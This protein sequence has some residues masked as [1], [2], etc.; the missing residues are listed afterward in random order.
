MFEEMI[1]DRREKIFKNNDQDA[2]N[3]MGD[4]LQEY[5]AQRKNTANEN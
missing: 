5:N 2:I 3:E 1:A 4:I